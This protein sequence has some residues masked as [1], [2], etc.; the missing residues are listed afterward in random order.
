MQ[1]LTTG[2]QEP[3]GAQTSA[4]A[5]GLTKGTWKAAG[6]KTGSGTYTFTT[7]R[8]GS[9]FKVARLHLTGSIGG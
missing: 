9:T 3:V 8:T 4:H 6:G 5:K 7:E 2:L 1:I